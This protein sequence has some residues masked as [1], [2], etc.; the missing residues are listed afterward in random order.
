MMT[1][2]KDFFVGYSPER[3]NPGDPDHTLEKITKIVAG[4]DERTTAWLADPGRISGGD[5]PVAR[6]GV[7]PVDLFFVNIVANR[8]KMLR[9][10]TGKRIA[11][12]SEADDANYST[13]R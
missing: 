8:L 3:I 10:C 13:F 12:V 5:D 6:L 1:C 11:Y 7:D 4:M 9:E 2:G